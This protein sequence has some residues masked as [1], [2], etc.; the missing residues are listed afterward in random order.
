MKKMIVAVFAVLTLG[1]CAAVGQLVKMPEPLPVPASL[2]PVQKSAAILI[3]E[4]LVALTA[5]YDLVDDL[6]KQ[7]LILKSEGKNY[8][9]VLDDAK[10]KIAVARD[11][12]A[13]G[14]ILNAKNEAELLNKG[15]VVLLEQLNKKKGSK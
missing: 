10:K 13:G 8:L 2:S 9:A 11:L 15:L 1:G 6:A 3:N 5:G 14:D 12:Y 4:A 7:K